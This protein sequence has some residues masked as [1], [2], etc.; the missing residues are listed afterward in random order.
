[1]D[2]DIDYYPYKE[3]DPLYFGEPLNPLI[4]HG[5]IERRKCRDIPCCAIYG[6]V[7]IAVIIIAVYSFLYGRP[8]LLMNPFD[9][10]GFQCGVSAGYE[11]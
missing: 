8:Y 1:M 10:S 11:S 7:W 3:A 2:S 5:P 9:S 4:Q 6:A